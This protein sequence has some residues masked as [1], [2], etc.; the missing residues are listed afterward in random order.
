MNR[1]TASGPPPFNKGGF[2]VGLL[3]IVFCFNTFDSL[4]Q[5]FACQAPEGHPSQL[6]IAQRFGCKQFT[7]LFA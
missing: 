3:F 4:R 6:Q 2:L 1:S 5:A 7:G